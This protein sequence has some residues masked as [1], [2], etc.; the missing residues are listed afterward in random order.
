M[1]STFVSA[2]SLCH[3]Y[4][5]HAENEIV[6][7]DGFAEWIVASL[8]HY[9]TR[10]ESLYQSNTETKVMVFYTKNFCA[11]SHLSSLRMRSQQCSNNKKSN[12]EW[13]V[14]ISPDKD[15]LE[16]FKCR[17]PNISKKTL[18]FTKHNSICPK[19]LQTS[20]ECYSAAAITTIDD[21]QSDRES[22]IV[23]NKRKRMRNG[24]KW[25]VQS[26]IVAWLAH[27]SAINK[28]FRILLSNIKGH[29]AM[30]AHI[31][32]CL[33]YV[34]A[35]IVAEDGS[36]MNVCRRT[37]QG[38]YD[39]RLPANDNADRRWCNRCSWLYVYV[40]ALRPTAA[41]CFFS[42][43]RQRSYVLIRSTCVSACATRWTNDTKQMCLCEFWIAAGV[44]IVFVS[45]TS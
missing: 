8:S 2:I 38:P 15:A 14:S 36:S 16:Q 33:S 22:G 43:S 30:C 1:S 37:T 41:E 40:I 25:Q 35:K 4:G 23:K 26:R 20:N 34:R 17:S 10:T 32:C 24:S 39:C 21:S 31:V 9:L 12:F 6:N 19:Q 13:I 29:T 45:C 28:T 42:C 27:A 7:H 5:T 44:M 18:S 3:G 11:N